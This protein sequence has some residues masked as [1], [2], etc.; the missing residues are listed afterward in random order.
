[1]LLHYMPQP[2]HW[3]GDTPICSDKTIKVRVDA[4]RSLLSHQAESDSPLFYPWY[5]MVLQ[6]VHFGQYCGVGEL[7][8]VELHKVFDVLI[9]KTIIYM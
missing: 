1:M 7:I 5:N 6:N 2:V 8:P 3:V 4:L 9:W